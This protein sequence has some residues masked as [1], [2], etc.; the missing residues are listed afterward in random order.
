M[1]YN[2]LCLRNNII[3]YSF[4]NFSMNIATFSDFVATYEID[5]K[6]KM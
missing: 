2:K 5:K 6:Y 4:V 1:S 3:G